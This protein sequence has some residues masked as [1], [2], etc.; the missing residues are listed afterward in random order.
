MQAVLR[1][2]FEVRA[3]WVILGI[4]LET[5][6]TSAKLLDINPSWIEFEVHD[7]DMESLESKSK[8]RMPHLQ[9]VNDS[10]HVGDAVR[11]RISPDN[12]HS[13]STVY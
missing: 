3:W 9:S 2:T 6:A 5:F 8:K 10:V 11:S 1:N 7:A 13:S 4:S 12:K